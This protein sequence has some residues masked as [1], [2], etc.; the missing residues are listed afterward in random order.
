MTHDA[1]LWRALLSALLGVACATDLR[2]RRIPNAL[3]ATTLAVAL[4][5]AALAAWGGAPGA[6]WGGGPALAAGPGAALLGAAGG[7]AVWLP[8]YAAGVLGAGDVKL[9]A[10]AAAWLGPH[11]VLP[12]SLYAGL[13]GGALGL[14]Y[15]ALG[16]RHRLAFALVAGPRAGALAGGSRD[17]RLPYGLA[18]A[19]GVL[20][21]AWGAPW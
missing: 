4:L 5:R 10:A 19:A 21:V 8:F 14:A 16:A 18:I 12:A 17:T 9:F 3:V 20:A 2:A 6:A 7:L 15:L 11:A 1:L 13:A